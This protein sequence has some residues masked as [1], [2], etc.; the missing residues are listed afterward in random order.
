MK[1]KGVCSTIFYDFEYL[2][3]LRNALNANYL[4]LTYFILGKRKSHV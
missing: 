2:L 1:Y 4:Y 3:P